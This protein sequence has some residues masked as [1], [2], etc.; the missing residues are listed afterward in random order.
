MA[1]SCTGSSTGVV[2]PVS[3]VSS[4]QPDG[5][6]SCAL[7]VELVNTR[8][9]TRQITSRNTLLIAQR[10]WSSFV[11]DIYLS[12][13]CYKSGGDRFGPIGAF[14]VRRLVSLNQAIW[15]GK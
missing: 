13:L 14:A 10:P 9:A 5:G 7:A 8:L 3:P 4:R 2:E 11:T 12:P 1:G 15:T 6:G